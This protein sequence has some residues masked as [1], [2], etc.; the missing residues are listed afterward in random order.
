MES[1]GT[2]PGPIIFDV[3]CRDGVLGLYRGRRV[4]YRSRDPRHI[5]DRAQALA[6]AT[7]ARSGLR[8]EVRF[9]DPDGVGVGETIAVNPDG[10]EEWRMPTRPLRSKGDAS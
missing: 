9:L 8:V 7:A 2:N 6:R 10:S 3:K 4:L 1:E 5:G